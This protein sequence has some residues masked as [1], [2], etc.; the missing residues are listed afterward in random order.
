M[1]LGFGWTCL[2][3]SWEVFGQV[4]VGLRVVNLQ[5]GQ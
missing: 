2:Y 3:P 4:R 5:E 1:F